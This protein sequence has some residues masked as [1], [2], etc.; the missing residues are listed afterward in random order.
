MKKLLLMTA[1]SLIF[2]FFP[3]EMLYSVT[4]GSKPKAETRYLVDMPTAGTLKKNYFGVLI[5]SFTANSLEMQ[6]EFSPFENF[7]FGVAYSGSNILGDGEP[8]F[9][10]YPGVLISY[11]FLNETINRPA[12]R[13]G[14]NTQGNGIYSVKETQF[15][16]YSPGI[17]LSS[18]KN[19][20]WILG[21]LAIHGG[22]NY[23]FEPN[24]DDRMVNF[25]SGIEQS[26]GPFAAVNLEYNFALEDNT[27]M[28]NNVG[29]ANL[30]LRFSLSDQITLELLARDLFNHL[31]ATNGI[32]RAIRLEII[33]D[34]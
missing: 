24:P 9:Q 20:S 13:I 4:A 11:R 2:L 15:E 22:I 6:M 29:L 3:Y 18:S 16:N 27:M 23:S 12:L 21:S 30:S 10:N 17:Y 19:F 28:M 14:I 33:N 26:A 8:T 31:R 25:Y 32:R 1:I 34:F 5:R 7:S